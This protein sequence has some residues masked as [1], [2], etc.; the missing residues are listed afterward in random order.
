M[1]LLF[2]LSGE[3]PTLPAAE[4]A[5]VG[6]VLEE[7]PQVAI[8]DVPD[9]ET[10]GRLALT[11][12]VL[13]LLGTCRADRESFR[14]MLSALGITSEVPFAGRV[15]KVHGTEMTAPV[16]E[17]ERMIGSL[18]SG[19]V[20]LDNPEVEYRAICTAELCY[21]GRVRPGPD[22]REF[23][24][25]RPGD[26]PFFH[27][28]VMM[29]RIARA[30]V[31][32]SCVRPGGILLDPFSG[33]GGILIEAGL[34]GAHPVGGDMDP[35]MLRGS[36]AN[37]PGLDLVR[38]DAASLPFPDGSI[39]AVVTDLPYGQSVTIRASTMDDLY[40]GTIREIDRVLAPGRRAVVVTHRDITGTAGEV[41]QIAGF[42]EQRIHRSLT[43]RILVLEHR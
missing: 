43:R 10:V 37:V 23:D 38:A 42:H 19:P 31:N 4:V 41:M 9:P 36:L 27:P 26:R 35:S 15:K 34:V 40:R 28:G 8:A 12:R 7:R 6:T 29:P 25:R 21:F 11:H 3:H 18:V 30:L 5:C 1:F 22:R 2:E 24:R 32:I 33:T 17:L 16:S 13:D 14:E 20:S 39:D